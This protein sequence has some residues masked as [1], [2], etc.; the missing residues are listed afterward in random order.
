MK[1]I[2]R[3]ITKI[4]FLL[5]SLYLFILAILLLKEGAR[6]VAPFAV[7]FF[8][9]EHPLNALGFGWLFSYL[10][11]SGS[12]VA[13]SALTFF[14]AGALDQIQ[15]FMMISGSRLGAA[16]IVL[17]VGFLYT[18]R[19]HE[20]RQ[21]MVMG[22]LSLLVT[23]TIYFPGL[24][25]GYF[26][27]T[28]HLLDFVQFGPGTEITS[29]LEQVFN[30]LLEPLAS[31]LPAAVLFVMGIGL[32][33]FSLNL[34]DRSLPKVN[35]QRTGFAQAAYLIYRPVVMFLLGLAITTISPSVSVSLSILV[36]LSA[37]GYVQQENVIP[38]IMGANIA[39]LSDTLV[40]AVLLNNPP[41]VTIVVVDIVSIGLVSLAILL[42]SYTHYKRILT[43]VVNAINRSRLYLFVFV[44]VSLLLPI[45]LLIL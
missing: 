44:L 18:V 30:P 2:R 22:L 41:A 33:L 17:L 26:L 20:R 42:F 13:A 14:D 6:A 15:A 11:L 16:F 36:P 8:R 27:L 35:L 40:V 21:S 45:A 31:F 24:V 10:I 25:L 23:A 5:A 38:Y 28:Y 4:I 29:F 39:T 43:S 12:P 7:Q 9:V 1:K 3:R 32:I 34:F 19:G 37:R